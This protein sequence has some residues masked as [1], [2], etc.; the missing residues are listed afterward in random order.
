VYFNVRL[1][2]DRSCILV[3]IGA[4]FQGQKELLGIRDG[5]RESEQ[6]WKEL[7]LDGAEGPGV[8][9]RSEARHR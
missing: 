1:E 8:G 3:V 4:N 7:L 6:S 2:D 5:F 9:D